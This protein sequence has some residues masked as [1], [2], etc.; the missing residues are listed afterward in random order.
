MHQKTCERFRSIKVRRE[1]IVEVSWRL[2]ETF[3]AKAQHLF[4]PEATRNRIFMMMA[5]AP[6]TMKVADILVLSRIDAKKPAWEINFEVSN[7]HGLKSI[8][9][10]FDKSGL[11]YEF[12]IE[13]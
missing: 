12:V 13:Q 7:L 1:D 9:S 2:K 8:L 5:V 10:H 11:P 6:D 3:I 4:V